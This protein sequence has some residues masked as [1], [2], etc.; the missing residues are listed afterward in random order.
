L[1]TPFAD[2]TQGFQTAANITGLSGGMV[3]ANFY[4][5][6]GQDVKITYKQG[7]TRGLIV[8]TYDDAA[9]DIHEGFKFD[10]IDMVETPLGNMLTVTIRMTIDAGAT[11]FSFFL[12][13]INVPGEQTVGFSTIGVYKDM[14][15]PIV[16]PREVKITWSSIQLS[17]SAQNV[18]VPL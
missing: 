9:R 10:Q 3:M 6:E 8:L 16:L 1:L 13:E 12:P 11:V 4:A 2:L 17:G 18:I 14:R 15:G 7:T 5:L